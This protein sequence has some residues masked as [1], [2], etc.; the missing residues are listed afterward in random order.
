MEETKIKFLIINSKS[1][2]ECSHAEKTN[3]V[4]LGNQVTVVN[5]VKNNKPL[6]RNQYPLRKRL[7]VITA[8]SKCILN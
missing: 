2:E 5:S 7:N 6:P 3:K 4:F 1:S 8:S